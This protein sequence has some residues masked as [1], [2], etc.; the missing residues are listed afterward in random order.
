MVSIYC[1]FPW[2]SNN[3][4]NCRLLNDIHVTIKD[5][6]TMTEESISCKWGEKAE[7]KTSAVTICWH[8]VGHDEQTHVLSHWGKTEKQTT[9]RKLLMR[10]FVSPVFDMMRGG[11]EEKVRPGERC[12]FSL[13]WS[14]W[15]KWPP[16]LPRSNGPTFA[17]DT[18]FLPGGMAMGQ[19]LG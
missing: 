12:S 19:S 7:M 5:N 16:F 2:K 14:P 3:W 8:D 9:V 17:G 6:T 1:I 13:K 11:N 15:L 18:L 10:N 4:W